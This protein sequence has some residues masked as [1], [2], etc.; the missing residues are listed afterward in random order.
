[1]QQQ[2][3]ACILGNKPYKTSSSSFRT[4][5]NSLPFVHII[6]SPS[7]LQES[8]PFSDLFLPKVNKEKKSS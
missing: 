3:T 8:S 5:T 7:H 2:M 6:I 4:K 1:M